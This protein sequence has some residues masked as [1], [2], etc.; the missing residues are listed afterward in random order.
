MHRNS[1]L[2]MDA[3]FFCSLCCCRLYSEFCIA[4]PNA[5]ISDYDNRGISN[6]LLIK[7]LQQQHSKYEDVKTLKSRKG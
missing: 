2:S 7:K 5:C 3:V 1:K 6:S 4:H